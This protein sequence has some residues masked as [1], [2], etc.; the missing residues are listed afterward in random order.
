MTNN[1]YDDRY[2][3]MD[4]DFDEIRYIDWFNYLLQDLKSQQ[5]EGIELSEYEVKL[6]EN[7][8]MILKC[9]GKYKKQLQVDE[10]YGDLIQEGLIILQNSIE[11][12]K[13]VVSGRSIKF[14]SYLFIQLEGYL[15]KAFNEKFRNIKVTQTAFKNKNVKTAELLL[16]Q[17]KDNEN[18]DDGSDNKYEHLLATIVNLDH[19]ILHIV[20]RDNLDKK[21]KELIN[22]H[23]FDGL[24]YSEIAE[25]LGVKS[26]GTI[27]YK[28]DKIIDKLFEK[29]N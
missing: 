8:R 10:E 22:L 9:C 15:Q 1:S 3:M 29:L 2:E 18:D 28:L 23:Y 27:K 17:G 6:L 19:E 14:S 25:K 4:R 20:M 5:Q 26:K 24:T 7:Y 12:Y 13:P 21:E 11:K 16:S